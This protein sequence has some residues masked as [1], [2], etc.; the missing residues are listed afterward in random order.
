MTGEKLEQ[1]TTT[2][3][4]RPYIDASPLF[5]QLRDEWAQLNATPNTTHQV[6]RW[7]R[8]EQVLA[9]FDSLDA[10]VTYLNSKPAQASADSVLAALIRLFQSG[11][12]L[13][14]RI[15][16]QCFLPKLAQMAKYTD[17]GVATTSMWIEERRQIVFA[18]FWDV[19]ANYPIERRTSSVAGNLALDT[20]HRITGAR[21]PP[22]VF[23]APLN[24][25][26]LADKAPLPDEAV[27]AEELGPESDLRQVLSWARDN[28]VITV[29]EAEMLSVVYLAAAGYGFDQA[30]DRWGLSRS[31]IKQR[32]SRVARRI[33]AAVRVELLDS[34]TPV[35]LGSQVA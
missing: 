20:L 19:L 12:Q 35:A 16:L 22:Q 3:A 25:H 30:A 21:K 29:E 6:R 2:G 24:D 28:R 11:H 8:R 31:A 10:V 9:G 7:A 14:G 32:C 18:E 17:R 4:V 23:E 27:H 26:S 1:A 5:R 34:E 13:A 33:A 15:V